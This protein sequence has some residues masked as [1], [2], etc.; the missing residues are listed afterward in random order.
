MCST[1][2]SRETPAPKKKGPLT[3]VLAGYPMQMVAVDILG[4]L[5]MTDNR[6]SYVL[7]A[8][9]YF[10]RW[11]EAYPIQNQEAVSIARKLALAF[12]FHYSIPEQLYTLGPR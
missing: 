5:P 6:N 2:A 11:A 10:T 9:D 7:V 1:C 3:P 4:P 12:F 8:S